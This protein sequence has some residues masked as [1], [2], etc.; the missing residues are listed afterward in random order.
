MRKLTTGTMI[1]AGVL[2]IGAA[3]PAKADLMLNATGIAD[4][5][6][7][8]TFVT[9]VPATSSSC[10]GPLGIATN[11]S[12]QVVMQ[13]YSNNNYVFNDVDGQTF[14]DKLSAASPAVTA[15]SYGMAITN[16]G[17]TLYSGN[18]DTGG[19]LI[20]LNADGSLNHVVTTTPGGTVAGHGIATN[21]VNGHIITSSGNGLWDINPATGAARQI[22]NTGGAVD[23]VSVSK[24]GTIVYGADSGFIVG[25]DIASGAVAYISPFLGSPDG[26]GVIAGSTPYAGDIIS[27][28]NDGTVWLLDPI[29]LLP[30]GNAFEEIASGGSRGDYVGVDGT[31]GSLFLTQTS[32]VDRLTCGT[33]CEFVGST[34]VPEPGSLALFGA[35]L[36]GLGLL[37]RRKRPAA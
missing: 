18:N 27:N 32:S 31:N 17:G 30:D 10:C 34:P 29:G 19:Q 5:F 20:Q 4:G 2:A 8:S 16:D 14:A 12:G 15:G 26:T 21:P 23:G 9:G 3:G 11:S 13:V 25:W 33:G 24:D 1:A 22:V 37:R 7:L 36:S 6:S 28:D 35:A